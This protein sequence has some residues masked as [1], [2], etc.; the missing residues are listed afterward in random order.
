MPSHPLPGFNYVQGL[1][2]KNMD[3]CVKVNAVL[4]HTNQKITHSEMHVSRSL[5][6]YA[7]Y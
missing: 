4:H 3:R 7:Q 1:L 6:K 2:I 5:T